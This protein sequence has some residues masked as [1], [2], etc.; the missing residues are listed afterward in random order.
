MTFKGDGYRGRPYRVPWCYSRCY[1]CT[2]SSAVQADKQVG[3]HHLSLAVLCWFVL[4]CLYRDKG[5][6]SDRAL[7]PEFLTE[8]SKL[9][10]RG[11]EGRGECQ[12]NEME[13]LKQ[14][15]WNNCFF[16]FSFF[17]ILIAREDVQVVL[18]FFVVVRWLV[19]FCF[20]FPFK[21]TGETKN[22]ALKDQN[23]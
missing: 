2:L 19:L 11:E 20:V 10:W 12:G 17:L 13:I 8:V 23:K 1:P 22:T 7:T 6:A 5:L 21:Y 15:N 3:W 4:I 9:W 18:L 16:F 14:M